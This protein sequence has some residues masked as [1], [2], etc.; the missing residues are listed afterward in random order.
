MAPPKEEE[1][2]REA[3]DEAVGEK[4]FEDVE[5][6]QKLFDKVRKKHRHSQ[7]KQKYLRQSQFRHRIKSWHATALR[8]CNSVLSP[9]LLGPFLNMDRPKPRPPGSH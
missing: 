2:G 8:V 3:V 7:I 6:E 5:Q 9:H 1:E 4:D